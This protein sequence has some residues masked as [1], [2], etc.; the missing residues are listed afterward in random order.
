MRRHWRLEPDLAFLNHGGFGACPIPVLE[1]QAAWRDRLEAQPVRFLARELEDHLDR[2]R[3]RVAAF[4]GAEPETVAFVPNATTAVAT[5][6]ASI[7]LRAGDEILATDHE[8][9]ATLNA[10][11]RVAADAGARVVI[12]HV[13]FPPASAAQAVDALLAA[14]SQRTRLALVS[15]V[16]SATALIMPIAEIV[17]ALRERGVETLV[18]GAHA[19]GMLPLD[20]GAIGAAW[21]AA[22]G[23]KWLCGPK[24]SAVLVARPDKLAAL[25]PLVTSHGANDDRPGRSRFR[26]EFDWTG[27]SDPTPQLTLPFAIDWLERLVP[28][29]W[30]AIRSANHAGLLEARD[31]LAEV[32]RADGQ[33]PPQMI[34]SMVTMPL[35]IDPRD[36]PAAA[37]LQLALADDDGVEVPIT[38]WPVRA[39][40]EPGA[41]PRAMLLRVSWQLYN[42]PW[43]LDR[44]VAALASRLGQRTTRYATAE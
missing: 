29:G 33:V 2:A 41:P 5:V 15:H 11:H 19:A 37:A 14:V 40:R 12:A 35:P 18:D 21:Y 34:G 32:V 38:A 13:P 8:Y 42:E 20:L 36:E 27:T 31:R 4:L 1:H 3:A 30:P 10:A 7:R 22:N 39:A 24:S 16:T 17:A 23:H 25:R 26:L 6:L 9:N 43:E 28:G 44:L